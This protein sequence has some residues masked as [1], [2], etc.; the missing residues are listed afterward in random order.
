MGV[1]FFLASPSYQA[2]YLL[3]HM[4]QH[5]FAF[6]IWLNIFVD[7]VVF[8]EHGCTAEEEAKFLTILVRE[9]GILNFTCVVTLFCV[10]YLGLSENKVQFLEKAGEAGAMKE[11]AYLEEFFTEIMEAEEFGEADSKRMVAMRGTGWIDYIREFHHQMHLSHPKAGQYKITLSHSVGKDIFRFCI[12]QSETS[13]NIKYC[14]LKKCKET[15][16]AGDE[17]EAVSKE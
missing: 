7:W 3:L 10:R 4:L 16:P 17:D 11:E 13:W 2:F 9:C 12:P 15:K 1:D 14:H 8:W 5:F 6:R